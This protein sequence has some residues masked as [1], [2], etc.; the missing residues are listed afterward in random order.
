[1]VAAALFLSGSALADTGYYRGT[2]GDEPWQLELTIDGNAVIGRLVHDWLPLS[3][4]AGGSFEEND[5]RVVA[6]FGLTGDELSGTLIGDHGEAGTFEGTMLSQGTVTP[7]SFEQVA[8]Y[9]DYK[10][11]QG[12]IEATSTYPFFVSPRLH[13]MN[14]FV[15]PDLM[16]AQ[17][18]FVQSAQDADLTG[19]V[20]SEWWSDS[21]ARIEYAAPGLLSA[22]VTVSSYTGGA[23]PS[24][25]YWSYNLALTG[26]RVRP[27]DLADLFVA[28]SDWERQLSDLI[29]AD[30]KQQGAAWVLDGSIS[31]VSGPAMQVFVISPAGL[32]F[33]LP[34]YEVG[35]WVEGTYTVLLGFDELE[36]LIDP[37]GPLRLLTPPQASLDTEAD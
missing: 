16:A 30:L 22:L 7:F 24:L 26:T 27:F 21:R 13:E 28:G 19:D 5:G 17:I 20:R 35:P 25:Q 2:I 11:E 29:I 12:N 36:G 8:Q 10:F 3:Y 34:P 32:Q 9:V 33:I 31:S 1:M 4:D 14:D 23:H 15:Q 6:R 18:E 37:D